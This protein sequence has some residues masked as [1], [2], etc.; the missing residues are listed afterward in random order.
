LI[1]TKAMQQL[2]SDIRQIIAEARERV[3][4]SV[5]HELVVAYWNIG[6]VIVEEQQQGRERAAYGENLIPML[7]KHLTGEFGEGFSANNLW[8][9]RDFF[10]CFPILDSV[11]QELTWT[12]YRL[13][14]RI[15]DAH[16]RDFFIAESVKNAWSVRQ[17]DRWAETHP[18]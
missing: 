17:L 6:R 16:K 13:L 11:R 14:V 3:A 2:L 4:R 10:L 5:N 18:Q 12:H 7:S 8:R 9:M 1:K 15:A